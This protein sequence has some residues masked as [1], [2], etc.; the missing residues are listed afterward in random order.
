[1]ALEPLIAAQ[2]RHAMSH[3][4]TTVRMTRVYGHGLVAIANDGGQLGLRQRPDCSEDHRQP[5]PIAAAWG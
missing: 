2:P 4:I 5:L 3:A 1:M